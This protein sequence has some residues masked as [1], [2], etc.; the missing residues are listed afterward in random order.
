MQPIIHKFLGWLD[1]S[2]HTF[3][4]TTGAWQN[5]IVNDYSTFKFE[6]T[7]VQLLTLRKASIVAKLIAASIKEG[8]YKALKDKV[9]VTIP[10]DYRLFMTKLLELG[11]LVPRPFSKRMYATKALCAQKSSL[12]ISPLCSFS[13]RY[14]L[15]SA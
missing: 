7:Y 15:S 4:K 9:Y 3:P 2:F 14:L 12:I 13:S 8:T 1:Y 11:V 10:V 6:I 5:L